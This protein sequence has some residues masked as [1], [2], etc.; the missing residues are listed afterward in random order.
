LGAR[1]P[2]CAPDYRG[3]GRIPLPRNWLA[4]EIRILFSEGQAAEAEFAEA[5]PKL[6]S[7]LKVEKGWTE[8]EVPLRVRKGP[9]PTL[10]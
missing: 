2:F 10:E 3:M 1:D 6:P 9:M 5:P 4:K 8:V 7:S